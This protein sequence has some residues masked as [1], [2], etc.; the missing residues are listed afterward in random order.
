MPRGGASL[1]TL[2]LA[3]DF[4]GSFLQPGCCNCPVHPGSDDRSASRPGPGE[5]NGDSGRAGPGQGQM[6]ADFPTSNCFCYLI[7][8]QAGKTTRPTPRISGHLLAGRG[9]FPGTEITLPD[10]AHT[11]ELRPGSC[12][13]RPPAIV[14]GGNRDMMQTLVPRGARGRKTSRGQGPP[15]GQQQSQARAL[16]ELRA[17]YGTTGFL[18]Q[19]PDLPG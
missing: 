7:M 18:C 6:A 3:V 15:A 2:G 19:N 4:G 16:S 10:A 8:S 17:L 11:R 14:G 9:K 1:G 5:M 13:Q 12:R